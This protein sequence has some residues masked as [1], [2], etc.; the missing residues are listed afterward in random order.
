MSEFKDHL[1]FRKKYYVSKFATIILI[2]E[3]VQMCRKTMRKINPTLEILQIGEA[4]LSV[5]TLT[6]SSFLGKSNNVDYGRT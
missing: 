1:G 3:G 4:P 2:C 6:T 5:L